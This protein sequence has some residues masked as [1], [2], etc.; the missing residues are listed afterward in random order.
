MK[1][2]VIISVFVGLLLAGLAVAFWGKL[3][4]DPG[5]LSHWLRAARGKDWSAEA[6]LGKPEAQ[7]F[8][9]L[10]LIRTNLITMV[11]RVPVLSRVPLVGKRFEEFR[12]EIDSSIAPEPLAE[13]HR[14]IKKAAGQ[15]FPPAMEAEKLFIGKLN[16]PNRASPPIQPPAKRLK[17]D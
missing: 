5:N 3:D 16:V 15:G 17:P 2:R 6:A 9:G 13:A 7:F 11:D 4:P 1:Q 14:W 8:L 10:T 12:Y